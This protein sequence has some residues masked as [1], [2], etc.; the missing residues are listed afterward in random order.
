MKTLLYNIQTNQV[1]SIRQGEYLVDGK[2]PK[3]PSHIVELQVVEQ[4]RPS[5][6]DTQKLSAEWVVD[7][8]NKEY[9]QEYTIYEKTKE[10]IAPHVITKAQGLLMLDQLG[11]Y[12]QFI[13]Q[14][15]GMTKREKIVF[16]ATKEW[17]YD[18]ALVNKFV[19]AFG[20]SEDQKMDFFIEASKIIV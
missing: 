13:T 19:E 4:E 16:E 10:E 6:P 9:R 12:E 11:L 7:L 15:E 18:N 17:E 8:E 20:F 2:K 1:G 3:L 14:I 5:I